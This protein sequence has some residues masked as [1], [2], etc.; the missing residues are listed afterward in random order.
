MNPLALILPA[1][2]IIGGAITFVMLPLPLAARL[3]I[4]A[5]DLAAAIVIAV[6]LWR[7]GNGDKAR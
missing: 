7:R 4:L 1:V 6:V 3:A 5:T 2:L